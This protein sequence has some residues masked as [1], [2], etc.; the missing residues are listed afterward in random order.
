MTYCTDTIHRTPLQES[1][2]TPTP[3][4]EVDVNSITPL[5]IQPVHDTHSIDID[6]SG[7]VYTNG[8]P[9]EIRG[10]SE[11]Y[12]DVTR[13]FTREFNSVFTFEHSD[14]NLTDDRDWFHKADFWQYVNTGDTNS[15][16]SIPYGYTGVHNADLDTQSLTS[17]EVVGYPFDSH[18][19]IAYKSPES[20][21][22]KVFASSTTS[23]PHAGIV[24]GLLFQPEFLVLAGI[25][26]DLHQFRVQSEVLTTDDEQTTTGISVSDR[27]IHRVEH[28]TRSNG[29]LCSEPVDVTVSSDLSEFIHACRDKTPQRVWTCNTSIPSHAIQLLREQSW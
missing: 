21:T 13:E 15:L 20:K 17:P 3:V 24:C 5:G 9:A 19:A 29:E 6:S 7:L 18:A 22:V 28:L 26:G 10:I 25:N 12:A 8:I 16:H 14:S 1:H 2:S 27:N 11:A 23:A 4:T